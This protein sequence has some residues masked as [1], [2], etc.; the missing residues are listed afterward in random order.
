M[1]TT[2]TNIDKTRTNK[3]GSAL[4][5][6]LS[7]WARFVVWIQGVYYVLMGLWPLLNISSFQQATGN[8][9]DLWLVKTVG[10]LMIVA[11]FVLVLSA[12]RRRVSLEMA[13][14]G[15]GYALALIIIEMV[16]GTIGIISPI[17]FLDSLMQALLIIGWFR[18]GGPYD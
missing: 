16:Y 3:S 13:V 2:G 18:R 11:G 17:Y 15:V 7:Y 9:T 12:Y 5:Y 14:L 4:Q 10:T 8:K 6:G 1:V